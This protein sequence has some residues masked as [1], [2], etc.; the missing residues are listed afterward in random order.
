MD[1]EG[2][3]VEV[4][5]GLLPAVAKGDMAPMIIFETHRSRYG[6]DHDMAAALRGLFDLGY[7]VPLAAS[8]QESGTALIEARGYRGSA[9]IATDGVTR[10]LFE[11]LGQDDAVDFICHTGGLRTVLLAR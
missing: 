2:H 4:I 5:N 3:E 7:R 8:S 6:A 9:P 11:D 1:V 10:V